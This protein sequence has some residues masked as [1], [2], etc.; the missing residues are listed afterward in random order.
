MRARAATA[1]ALAPHTHR[2]SLRMCPT[3]CPNAQPARRACAH[4][5]LIPGRFRA[6][7][8]RGW[9]VSCWTVS[10]L[11]DFAGGR[12]RA[13]TVTRQDG[14]APGRL[15]ARTVT[16][17]MVRTGGSNGWFG[18]GSYE[19]TIRTTHSNLEIG[20]GSDGWFE[21]GSYVIR[22]GGCSYGV[23]MKFVRTT[24]VCSG[25]PLSRRSSTSGVSERRVDSHRLRTW[26][27][28]AAGQKPYTKY[29]KGHQATIPHIL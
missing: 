9:T 6:G 22:R 26:W 8:F 25:A 12:L 11:D 7:R 20:A 21:W 16:V 3:A 15:L 2:M 14:Y 27:T 10:R 4:A 17:V 1:L 19:P 23:R 24:S 18:W 5:A 29:A 13:R 28:E